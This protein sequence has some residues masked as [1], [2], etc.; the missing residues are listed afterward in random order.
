M[1]SQQRPSVH[2]PD[3]RTPVIIGVGQ[4][5]NRNESLDDAL[6]PVALM[7]Q[8]VLAASSDAQL[9]GPPRADAVRVVGQLSWRYGNV[10]RFLAERLGV[11]PARLDY[12]TMGGNSPQSLINAT[13]LQIQDG[14]IDIAVLAGGEATRTRQRGRAA[15]IEFDWP[16]SQPETS[17]P[18][19]ARNW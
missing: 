18:S 5:V 14:E 8:A 3:D 10:P 1:T 7:E 2:Q 9:D 15:G 4:F 19:S 13:A 17:P 16:K 6:E 12:T 11:E